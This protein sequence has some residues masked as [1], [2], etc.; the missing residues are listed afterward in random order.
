MYALLTA[1]LLAQTSVTIG[2]GNKSKKPDSVAAAKEEARADSTRLRREARR[3]SIVARRVVNDSTQK[4]RR[5]AKRVALTPTLMANA[6]KDRRASNLL[7]AARVA[8][9]RHDS[10]LSGYD[11]TTYERMSVGVGFKRI[12]RERLLMRAE[13][14]ARVVWSRGHPA[15]VEILGK[16]EVMPMFDGEAEI[17]MND[18]VPMPY[19]P[20]R[21]TLWIGSGLAKAD[22]NDSEFI[23]PL[24]RGSE[25]YY[26]YAIGDSVSFQLPGGRRIELR[27]LLVRPRAPAWNVALGSLWFDVASSQLVRA[28]YRLAE[29][30]DIWSAAKEDAQD[31]DDKPPKWVTAMINPLTAYV[32]SVTVE[33]GLHEGKFWLPRLQA[34]EGGA[35]AGF[36]RAPFKIE[37]SFKYASVNGTSPVPVPVIAYADTARDSVSR[38]ERFKRRRQECKEGGDRVRTVTRRDQ[39][40][41][42]VVKQ[43]CDSV[44][45]AHSPELPKS[46]YDDGEELFGVK[47]R[48]ALIDA[49]LTLGAQPGWVPQR[50]VVTYGLG[51]TRY[52]RIEGLSSGI[53]ARQSLGGGYTARAS[54]R[55]GVADWAPNPEIGLSRTDG[56]RTLGVTAYRRLSSA[57]DFADPFTFGSSL[58][59]L[60]F[61]RDEGFYYRTLGL[62]LTGSLS[63][64]TTA[65]RLFA[66]RHGD[67]TKKTDFS[68]ANAIGDKLFRDN[69]DAENGNVIGI[70]AERH[71]SRGLDP[72]G[73][74]LFG[75]VRAEAAA[76]DFDYS[77][78]MFDATVSHGITRKLDGALTLS[79]GTSGGHVPSQRLWYLGGTQSIR[80]QQAGAAIGNAFWMTRVELGGSFVGARP[81]IFGDLGWAGKRDDFSNPGRPISGAGVGASFMDGLVRFDIA[82]GIYPE[83]KIRTNL[84]VEA[85]F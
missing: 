62:E 60:L 82:R 29:P 68:P 52:N 79:A 74:R 19:Y 56:R 20:G 72:H 49:A 2:V 48:D 73:L 55:I 50:P 83:K 54:V 64:S 70:G 23:H 35:T 7:E 15:F 34:M 6:F 57:S 24:A 45:L 71:G 63:D 37:Q 10:S 47:E 44:A 28:V 31:D 61:G 9:L 75:V 65:L 69:I 59:A 40:M 26:T 1:L 33:Y 25:A 13:R 8:R 38:A 67:A 58:S 43:S 77:R 78:A 27:E 32:N 41:T 76:G 18:G 14:A 39:G 12:G 3:D 80:G 84:Y 17:D 66:E 5:R 11:A 4:E 81:V 42:M 53:A 46:I 21:E 85:R 16:R 30:L 36:M 51:M 22:I